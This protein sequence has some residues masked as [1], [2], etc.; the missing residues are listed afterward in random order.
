MK[1]PAREQLIPGYE[2]RGTELGAPG[3]SRSNPNAAIY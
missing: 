3:G 2:G 1:K